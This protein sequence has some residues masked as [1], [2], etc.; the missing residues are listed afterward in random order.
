MAIRTLAPNIREHRPG[1]A[2]RARNALVHSPQ[3]K[4]RLI[5][6]ELGNVPD[7]LPSGNRVAILALNIKFSV[8]TARFA[9]SL[10]IRPRLSERK[11]CRQ[12]K[13]AG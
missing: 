9:T 5:V 4:A 10:R 1:V 7:R 12:K 6:I 13:D 11:Q 2:L 8:G 3:R